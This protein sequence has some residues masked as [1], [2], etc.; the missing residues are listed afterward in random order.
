MLKHLMDKFPEVCLGG[1]GL[2]E[3]LER[4]SSFWAKYR[5][6]E[7]GH[8]V[9]QKFSDDE[10]RRVIPYCLHG[11]KGRTLK[12]SPIANYSIESVWGLPACM[13]DGCEDNMSRCK[14]PHATWSNT[15]AERALACG[16]PWPCQDVDGEC[17]ISK[18]Q[19]WSND[20]CQEACNSMGHSFLTKFLLACVPHGVFS[21]E[22]QT[23]LPAL[24][25]EIAAECQDL[26]NDGIYVARAGV[27]YFFACIGCKGD[28]EFHVA[29]AKLPTDAQKPFHADV[30]LEPPVGGGDME[31]W[32][33]LDRT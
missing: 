26:F 1:D 12:K 13:R 20:S 29:R 33:S 19:R 8:A 6:A 7:P 5:L 21:E 9:F 3:G 15:C 31:K 24:L 16:F 30:N 10:L 17:T 4:C 23:I 11:D 18:R 2:V 22:P 27:T 28:A 25:R 14:K 32:R